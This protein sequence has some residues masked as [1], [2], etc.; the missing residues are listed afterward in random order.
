MS[1]SLSNAD[2]KTEPTIGIICEYNP[3]HKGHAWQIAELR[4]RYPGCTVVCAMSGSFVQRGEAAMLSKYAR[5]RAAT[6]LGADVV[7]EL[8]PPHALAPAELFARGGVSLLAAVGCDALC[9]GAE[10]PLGVTEDALADTLSL[11]AVRLD[12]EEFRAALSQ[13]QTLPENAALG[14]PVLREQVYAA[15]WGQDDAA[16]LRTPNNILAIEYLRAIRA[17]GADMTPIAIPRA[18]AAHDAPLS[19]EPSA[20]N[21]ESSPIVSASAIRTCLSAG[22]DERAASLLPAESA[23][24]LRCE[25]ANGR[26]A[27]HPD[28]VLGALLLYRYRT[29]SPDTLSH[30]AGLGG[31]L[32]HRF[33]RAAR[34]SADLA[35]F[36]SL[37]AAKNLTS[38]AIR[39]AALC[40]LLEI[41]LSEQQSPPPY[42]N[43]L[44]RADT[45]NAS[46]FL[47]RAQK[48]AS[49]P[50]LARPA[51]YR[52][53]DA[54]TQALV[55]RYTQADELW[56]ML[57]ERPIPSADW[58]RANV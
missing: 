21:P 23:E 55:K 27:H 26:L 5:A 37:A 56:G 11:A 7:L 4:R 13:A 14:Y 12:S 42:T 25:L 50:I 9:F 22:E 43:L 33:C 53:L 18:G 58:M 34:E 57:T 16:V 35:G 19:S 41:S 31:G 36:W 48:N 46:A 20:P 28:P 6:A 3:P 47:R 38:A 44:A 1:R 29:A 39:R 54:K 10:L 49:L 52:G 30:F 15:Y 51:A 40:G 24:M 32:S 17:V 45:E 2:M 8:L